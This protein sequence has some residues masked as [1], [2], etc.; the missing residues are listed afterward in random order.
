MT[1]DQLTFSQVHGYKELPKQLKLESLP[2]DARHR[3]WNT[4]YTVLARSTTEDVW[5]NAVLG[6]PWSGIFQDIHASFYGLPL[7]EWRSDFARF[8]HALRGQIETLP[9]N[10][11]FDLIQAVLRD[12]R[13]PMPFLPAMK[14]TFAESRLAYTIDAGPPAT[15]VPAATREEGKALLESLQTLGRAG[16][17]ASAAHLRK[18]AECMNGG[19]WAGSI[20]ESI[21]AVESAARQLDPDASK[22]LGPAL[23]SLERSKP[24]HPTLKAAFGTLYGYTS[25]EEGIRHSL[26]E[27]SDAPV[28][29]NEAV[30]MLSACAAF[31]SYLCRAT[32]DS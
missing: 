17:N 4:F 1:R 8:R 11:V 14:R 9:F 12:E 28:G 27:H 6:R 22:G 32:E 23:R 15:I 13:C 7:D 3:I 10:E 31:S 25:K 2:L 26:L 18:S 5:G 16:Q 30:F 20:R 24:L 19:D 21:H 29:Q